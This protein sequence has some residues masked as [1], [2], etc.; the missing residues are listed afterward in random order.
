MEPRKTFRPWSPN[1]YV[2]Q[3]VTP[4]EILPEDDLVFFLLETI[5][6]LDLSAFYAHYEGET[7]GAPPYDVDMMC[8]L[9]V[10]GYSVGVFSSRKIA[11][12]C[13]RNLAFMAIVGHDRPD[14]RTISDFRK[15]HLK[16]FEDLFVKVLQLA[17]EV[18]MVKL[19]NLALDGSKFKANASRHKAMSYGYMKKDIE[20]LRAEIQELTS[21]ANQTD[22][23]EDAAL[24]SRRG[25]ELPNELKRREDRLAVL[26]A[27]MKRLEAEAQEK[28]NAEQRRRDEAEAKREAEGKKRRGRT[29]KPIDPTPEDKAQTNFTDPESK[30]MKTSNKGFDYCINGQAVVDEENQ[31]IVGADVTQDANDK[32][33]AGVMAKKT[34]ETLEAAGIELPHD[35]DEANAEQPEAKEPQAEKNAR[36]QERIPMSMDSGYF[37]EDAVGDVEA[38]GFDP[39]IAVGRQKHHTPSPETVDGAPP[40]GL[41]VKEKM[42]HKLRTPSGRACY[43][44]RKQIVEPVFGLMK[45]VRGFRQFLLRGLNKVRGEWNLLCLTHNLLKIWRHKYAPT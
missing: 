43:A 22:A 6:S 19:G 41:T 42:A 39:H 4:A 1:Q 27:A 29:P 5:P 14:F 25:D 28:A 10:Y 23:E 20:R 21:K 15:I 12:A 34:R 35:A 31:I 30:I 26:E 9:L 3:P 38:E 8:T 32:Q 17:V 37:S 40:E 18:R 24:G 11:L 44:K 45:H 16:A 13:E 33:Q 7:R 36:P 2:H